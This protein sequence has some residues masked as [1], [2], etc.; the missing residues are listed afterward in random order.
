M[1]PSCTLCAVV[2][3]L[4]FC[5]SPQDYR[6][7][8]VQAHCTDRCGGPV[9]VYR[10]PA[11]GCH[12]R[13]QGRGPGSQNTAKTGG[14]GAEIQ[15]GWGPGSQNTARA[16]SREPQYSKDGGQG[17]KIQQGRGPGSQITARTGSR[18]IISV[19]YKHTVHSNG[20]AGG[21]TGPRDPTPR[22]FPDCLAI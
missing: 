14:H 17:A 3:T 18:E 12:S 10:L 15:Q 6:P 5:L 16:G 21:V 2:V 20:R 22:L 19:L 4:G 1:S 13:R 7:L 11:A 9:R 8:C